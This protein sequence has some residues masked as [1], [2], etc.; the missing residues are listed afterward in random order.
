M[1]DSLMTRIESLMPKFS[2]GQKL[3]A[4]YIQTEYGQAAF[5]TAAKLGET[6]GVSES[7]VVRFATELGYSGY[8][9]M[10]QA[11]QEMI[12]DKLTSFQRIEVSQARIG[13]GS[14]IEHVLNNDID[15]IKQ[16]IEET[17]REDFKNSVTAIS[18]AKTIYIY[19]LRS[20]S[21]L[22][23]FLGYYL[24]L[25]FGNVKIIATADKA[26]MYEELNRIG[27]DD[28]MIG[29]SFPRYSHH[30][31]NAMKFAMDRNA[32]VIALTDSMN[33]PIAQTATYVLLAR[34]DM[35]T[36]VDS[37]VAPLSLINALV[38]ATVIEKKDDVV[39]TFKELE[40]IWYNY[41]VYNKK[42]NDDMED[43]DNNKLG[44]NIDDTN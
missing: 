13:N 12:R 7:T 27:A 9:K 17:S 6:V 25:I 26:R 33:S 5:M 38:V 34:S 16:T 42:P 8:P 29:I 31:S 14:V 40:K 37:L 21:A 18:Q 1:V 19:A 35:A 11:M 41:G 4:K 30:T 15:N 28:V 39:K 44:E 43:S 32:K 23:N 10:Q 24:N 22:A 3:I 36:I 20:S 2:K